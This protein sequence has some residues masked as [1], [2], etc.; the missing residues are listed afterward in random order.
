MMRNFVLAAAGVLLFAASAAAEGPS[1]VGGPH[2]AGDFVTAR[3]E[4]TDEM[5][6]HEPRP[7]GH[8]RLHNVLSKMRYV[9]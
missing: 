5:G 1:P 4:R 9:L 8:E 2:E 3:P 7:A 6:A